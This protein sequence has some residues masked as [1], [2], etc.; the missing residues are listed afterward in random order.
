MQLTR[1]FR[2]K[3][4][5][6]LVGQDKLI[7]KVRGLLKKRMQNAWLFTGESGSGKTTVARIMALSFQCKHQDKFGNPCKKCQ[8]NRNS[9]D[10][11]E[12]NASQESGKVEMLNLV[13]DS[14]LYPKH[15]SKYRVYILD[16]FQ[17]LSDS[18]QNM[19]LKKT[20]DSPKTCIWILCTSESDK[21]IKAIWRR[22]KSIGL[23]PLDE[24][25]I[26]ELIRRVLKFAHE[27]EE[28]CS[29]LKLCE[30]LIENGVTS[31]GFI[32]KAVENKLAG[33]SYEESAVVEFTSTFDPR[34]LIR[35]I[36]K[37]D[38]DGVR[39]ALADTSKE[40]ARAIRS[41][42]SSY[43]SVALIESQEMDDRTEAIAKAIEKLT[44][45]AGENSTIL[46]RVRAACF[47]ATK[48]FYK[49][50]R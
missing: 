16:E 46:A 8:K 2:P 39:E 27:S 4:F 36:V 17:K 15:G 22:V 44:D 41:V 49:H 47:Y 26:R 11:R 21:V 5:K 37:G 29:P 18:T 25:N 50:P 48:I 6:E 1:D 14:D 7:H 35:S 34:K 28:E 24:E 19:L 13:S 33:S 20:E 45:A 3:T 30:A 10:I 32:V 31:S 43:L 40:D 9:F 42:I 38:W 12:I 23:E